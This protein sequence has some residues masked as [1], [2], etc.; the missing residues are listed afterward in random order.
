VARP[1]PEAAPVIIATL[2]PISMEI[3]SASRN[4]YKTVFGGLADG[5]RTDPMDVADGPFTER[6]VS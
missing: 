3:G 5:P 4:C 1:I 6:I 2:P